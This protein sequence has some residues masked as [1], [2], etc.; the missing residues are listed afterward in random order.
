[1]TAES[2]RP[3]A[4]VLGLGHPRQTAYVKSLAKFGV[5]VHAMHSERSIYVASR[6][7]TRFHLLDRDAQSQ[8]ADIESLGKR[9]G[10]GFLVPTNDD[11]VALVSQN[12]ERLSKNFLIPLPG[13]EAIGE[14]FDRA[15]C[16][17][18]ASAAGIAV[19][20]YWMPTSDAGMKEAV[21]ALEPHKSDYIIKTPSIL[22]A[23]ANEA[24]IRLT[25]AAPK[26]HRDIL[27]SCEELKRRTGEY[28]MIQQVVP[29]AADSAIGVTMIVSRKGDIVLTY[30]VRRLRLASYRIDAGYVHPYE[31]G[32]VV[33]CETTHDDEAVEAARELVRAFRYYGQI[34]VEFRRDAR[35]GSL[36]LMK[37]EPRPVRATSLSSAIGMDIPTILYRVFLGESVEVPKEYPDGVGWLWTMAYGQSLF[38]NPHHNRRDLLRVLRSSNRIRAFAEDFADPMLLTRWVARSAARRMRGLFGRTGPKRSLSEAR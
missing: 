1:M 19:P 36:H 15:K 12:L 26:Q 28:P 17:A 29:G 32:S 23:P 3:P 38:H 10:R 20:Q 21:G 31:L 11:N 27:A 35:D 14:I 7:L 18:K 9:L 6:R 22:S 5:P 16:Y 4:V 25:K 24:A 33:W 13:W 8:L 37:V 34:T 30:C 2:K